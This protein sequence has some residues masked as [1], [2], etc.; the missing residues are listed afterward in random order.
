MGDIPSLTVAEND[1]DIIIKAASGT[2]I[3]E[4]DKASGVIKNWKVSTSPRECIDYCM[5]WRQSKS[6]GFSKLNR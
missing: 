6:S 1:T 5:N 4:F 3:M 2:W